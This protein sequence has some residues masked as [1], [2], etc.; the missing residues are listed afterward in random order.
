[1]ADPLKPVGDDLILSNETGRA[2]TIGQ[3]AAHGS[4]HLAVYTEIND[5]FSVVFDT[6]GVPVS[7]RVDLVPTES[8]TG[9]VTNTATDLLRLADGSGYM[10]ALNSGGGLFGFGTTLF[11][12]LKLDSDGA[13]VG[14]PVEIVRGSG[15]QAVSVKVAQLDDGGFVY[16]WSDASFDPVIGSDFKIG[17][18]IYNA[19]GTPRTDATTIVD[20]SGNVLLTD[21]EATADGGFT[22]AFTDQSS[23][24]FGESSLL[25]FKPDGTEDETQKTFD[26]GALAAFSILADGSFAAA[27]VVKSG[28][29]GSPG[30]Q[31]LSVQIVDAA[32][33]PVVAE[34]TVDSISVSPFGGDA[35]SAPI[36]LALA[37]GGFVI[38]WTKSLR[39]SGTNEDVWARQYDATGAAVGD[40]FMVNA[41]APGGQFLND[42]ALL[43][44]GRVI[45]G[46]NNSS[47][48]PVENDV[49]YRILSDKAPT[50]TD[51]PDTLVGGPDVDIFDGKGGDDSIDGRAGAD[52]LLGGLGADT[53]DG[54]TTPDGA[55]DVLIGG[56][57]DDTYFV[58]S[59]LDIVDEGALF[60]EFGF[61]GIDTIIST[62]D[63]YWDVYSA[64]ETLRVSEDVVDVGGDGVTIVGGVFA[65]TLVGHTGTD[66]MFGRGGADTYRGGDGVDFMSLSLLGTEGAYEGVDGVNTIVMDVRVEGLF[67]YDIVF[68]F[69]TGKDKIDVSAYVEVN[70]LVSGEDL[71]ARAV[72]DGFGSSYIPLGDGLDYLYMVGV[73]RDSLVASDFILTT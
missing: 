49:L 13:P 20:R 37:D 4:G 56:E 18:R 32:G 30:T 35:I 27:Q 31:A 63:F 46:W 14:T 54:G 16:V 38:G 55:S 71:I 17:A 53:L 58:D 73:S 1:M 12:F 48:S 3:Y 22:V 52:T 60:P 51:G 41:D 68:E 23:G 62:A 34:F 21:V 25:A 42:L 33:L 5:I 28:G 61:G 65:T 39:D 72:D 66:V 2:E 36:I 69:E 26:T 64:A 19:D 24:G 40:A 11:R 15:L 67:S 7:S 9:Q 50:G 29:F 57:G 70:A 10:L 59:G 8:V 47:P 6:S 45:A 44:D 43:D